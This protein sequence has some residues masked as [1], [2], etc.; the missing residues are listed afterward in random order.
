MALILQA[1]PSSIHITCNA[2]TTPNHIGVWGIVGHFTSEEGVLCDLLLSLSEQQGSHSGFNQA[3][4]VLNTLT[5]YKIRNRLGHFVMNDATTND[6]LMDHISA[7]LE[8]K[9]IVYDAR[10]HRL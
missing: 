3:Q 10:Q 7:D 6:A 5:V 8:T 9:G 4:M 2:W 1:A